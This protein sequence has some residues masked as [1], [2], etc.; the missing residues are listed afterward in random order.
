MRC[1]LSCF[2]IRIYVMVLPFMAI[3]LII[4][5]CVPFQV[6]KKQQSVAFYPLDS[7]RELTRLTADLSLDSKP[8]ISPNGQILA[9][10][11]KKHGD[12]DIFISDTMAKN[13]QQITLSRNSDNNPA[14][15]PDKKSMLFVSGRFGFGAI[16][17]KNLNQE[18]IT[19][20]VVAR[21]ANDFAPDVSPDGKAIVFGSLTSGI[22]SLWTA[23]IEGANLTQ[24]GEGIFP[25]WSPDGEK[26]L[27]ISSK[28]GNSD[29]WLVNPDGSNLNQITVNIA[30]DID[31]S[32]SP[33]G[34]KIVF[35]SNRTGNFDIWVLD[36][37]VD[38]LTQ[39]THHPGDDKNP[40]WSPDGK[41]I[42]FDSHRNGNMDIWRLMPVL[43]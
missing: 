42:Y 18:R 40:N 33:E 11:S 31:P 19:Y 35:S 13:P 1:D 22:E 7:I 41:Y 16:F 4:V 6:G 30:E 2:S 8:V 20:Q 12:S 27:F 38:R 37:K 3:S 10:V 43:E 23:S 28:G 25:K 17:K 26:I 15:T 39:L 36:L 9:F 24:I 29:V 14:W 34:D 32:W 5:G 21:G